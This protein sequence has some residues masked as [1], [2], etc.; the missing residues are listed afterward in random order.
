MSVC[1][2]S[3][4]LSSCECAS[5]PFGFD[6]GMWDLIVLIYLLVI[7]FLFTLNNVQNKAARVAVRT[8]N[9]FL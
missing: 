8:T 6:G 9:S 1:I 3:G 2:W 4:H 7:S 5:F